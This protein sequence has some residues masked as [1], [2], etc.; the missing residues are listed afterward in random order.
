[1]D[2]FL[3]SPYRERHGPHCARSLAVSV[4]PRVRSGLDVLRDRD[5]A[6]L[7]GLRIGVVTHPAAVDGNLRHICELLTGHPHVNVA[8]IFGPE[9]GLFGHA[10]DLIGVGDAA[11]ARCGLRT[12]SLYGDTFDSLK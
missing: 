5:F 4:M 10:Q 9:H 12:Y 3:V 11:E 8:A 7:R 1:L 2:G 6:P